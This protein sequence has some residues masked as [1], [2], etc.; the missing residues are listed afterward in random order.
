MS[1]YFQNKMPN[2][3]LDS[4]DN[5]ISETSIKIYFL[6]VKIYSFLNFL[7]IVFCLREHFG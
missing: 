7:A 4:M 2:F 3:G 5:G 6:T 1:I